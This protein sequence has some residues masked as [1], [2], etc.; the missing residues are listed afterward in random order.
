[1]ILSSFAFIHPLSETMIAPAINV[2]ATNLHFSN[3]YDSMLCLSTFLIGIA[4]GPLILAP[5]SEVYGRRP[6]L[7]SGGLFYTIWTT[8]CGF[9]KSKAQLFILRTLSGFGGSVALAIGGGVIGDVWTADRRARALAWYLLAPLL[10]PAIGP[11]VGGFVTDAGSWRWVFWAF[12]IA[13]FVFL[14]VAVLF[15]PESHEPTLARQHTRRRTH[16]KKKSNIVNSLKTTTNL[17]R[18]SLIR[19][20]HII[21]TQPVVIILA[22]LM[23]L[24][25]GIMFLFIFSY[26]MM[27]ID[28]YHES[29]GISSLNYISAGLGYTIGAQGACITPYDGLA[30]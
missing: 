29:I 1:M 19:P 12:A 5:L 21:T 20:L 10:G 9:A 11:I 8:A 16:E 30:Y 2:I 13:S 14:G 27:W 3:Q 4:V 28:I 26:P 18:R 24:L 25:Y 7:L 6:V 15:F 17:L 23:A 22:I